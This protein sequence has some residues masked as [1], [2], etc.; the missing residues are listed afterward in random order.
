MAQPHSSTRQL[1]LE[2]LFLTESQGERIQPHKG[3]CPH[4]G[5][6]FNYNSITPIFEDNDPRTT[7]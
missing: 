3:R 1:G 6:E 2:S 7:I 5:A 4:C